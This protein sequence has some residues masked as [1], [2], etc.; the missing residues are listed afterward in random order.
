MES[1]HPTTNILSDAADFLLMPLAGD[2]STPSQLQLLLEKYNMDVAQIVAAV[3]KLNI[4]T[5]KKFMHRSQE[6]SGGKE[7]L[8]C[9]PA[10]GEIIVHGTDCYSM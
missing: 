5:A 4:D 10:L 7:S 2:H 3:A 8:L 6:Y 1:T 9:S